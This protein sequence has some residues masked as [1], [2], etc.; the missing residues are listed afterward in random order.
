[1]IKFKDYTILIVED[2]FIAMEYLSQILLS[3]RA[4]DIY[5]AKSAD[6]ALEIVRAN[7]IDLVFMDINIE[8][9]MD[10][11]ECASLLNKDN[12]VPI[13]FTSAYGDTNTLNEAK[14]EN[15]FGYLI[16]P[17]QPSDVEASLLIAISII[18]R[19]K[20][21]SLSEKQKITQVVDLSKGYIYHI[22]SKTLTLYNNPI[23]LTKK[24]LE[25]LDILCN[26][27]NQNVSY[28]YLKESIWPQKEISD[29][30]IRDVVSRLKKKIP[31]IYI[32]NISNYG[33]ILKGSN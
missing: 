4:K 17:F 28:N 5:R 10:G 9:S 27:L 22:D 23:D 20:K 26:N 3:F 25:F 15:V 32:E 18:N 19:I 11:I 30:T 6:E 16:K 29:S 31:H 13:I 7:S 21:F 12:F 2:E 14:D 8:G 1:M 33:Y 24:E